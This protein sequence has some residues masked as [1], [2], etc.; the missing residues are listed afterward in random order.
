VG[1]EFGKVVAF[2]LNNEKK[3]AKKPRHD[4][5]EKKKKKKRKGKRKR[6]RKKKERE[7]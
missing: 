2:K 1:K 4:K 3:I 6:K 7:E 5:E